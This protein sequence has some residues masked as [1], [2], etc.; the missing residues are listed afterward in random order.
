MIRNLPLTI[1]WQ[2][3]DRPVERVVAIFPDLSRFEEHTGRSLSDLATDMKA[4]DLTAIA[5]FALKRRGEV[6]D[7]KRPQAWS[8]A[9]VAWIDPDLDGE[10]AD[11]TPPGP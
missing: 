9:E 10:D 11:P 4:S 1:A 2:D 8:E 3:D 7:Y 6:G 5:F